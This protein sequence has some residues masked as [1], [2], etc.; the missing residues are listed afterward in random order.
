MSEIVADSSILASIL[1]Q[2]KRKPDL[3][4]RVG[5]S[6]CM[7]PSTLAR[8]EMCNAVCK[9]REISVEDRQKRMRQAWSTP[10]EEVPPDV[11]LEKAIEIAALHRSSFTDA[12]FIA[13][14]AVKQIPLL[15]LDHRQADTAR[16][17]GVSVELF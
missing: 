12:C 15:T 10:L 4:E 17:A 7:A 8:Y 2:E 9:H 16:A 11:W 6:D 3:V 5:T 13:L 14:A 1:L